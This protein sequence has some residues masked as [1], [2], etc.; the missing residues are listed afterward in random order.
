MREAFSEASRRSPFLARRLRPIGAD[1]MLDR[2]QA[3]TAAQSDSS[4]AKL[5]A[6]G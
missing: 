3:T 6:H 1:E 4:A 5:E 2:Y